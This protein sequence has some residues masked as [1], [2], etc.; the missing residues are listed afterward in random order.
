VE[1][2]RRSRGLAEL[3]GSAEFERQ[4]KAASIKDMSNRW[5]DDLIA[6]QQDL[7]DDLLRED[8]PQDGYQ[9]ADRAEQIHE[10]VGRWPGAARRLSSPAPAGVEG[11]R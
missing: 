5:R 10:T 2:C 9:G 3:P 6:A 7:L 8:L 11:R 1:T 4:V